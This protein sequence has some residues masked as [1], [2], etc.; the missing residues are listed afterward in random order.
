MKT[1]ACFVAIYLCCLAYNAEGQPQNKTSNKG[2]VTVIFKNL[3]NN[4]PI[5]LYDSSYTNPFGEN[6]VISKFK[7]Y[8]SAVTLYASRKSS[9]EK[10]SYH[11]INQAVDSSLYFSISLPENNYDSIGFLLGVDS[12]RNTAGAQTGA[13]D[14]LNDMFW[15]WHT[16]YVMEKLE[17]TSPQS[18]AVNNKMEYHLGGFS[19]ENNVLNY[20]TLR[21]PGNKKLIIKKGK[22]SSIVMEVDVNKFWNTGKEIKICTTQVCTSPGLL[23][24]Q[25]A[26]NFSRLFTISEVISAD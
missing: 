14:P 22:T 1:A 6:Y 25:M 20:I 24:K 17:G 2:T 5:V 3:V 18:N 12:A 7:Y 23:A 19:G 16:G 9:K 8:I 4:N 11:L 21:F 10:N 15:T 13:L 26:G